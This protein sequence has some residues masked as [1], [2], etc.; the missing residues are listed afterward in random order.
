M[1]GMH[2]RNDA[3]GTASVR[4]GQ[5]PR[6]QVPGIQRATDEPP[7]FPTVRTA[8]RWA[9]QMEGATF[10]KSPQYGPPPPRRA[11]TLDGL[12]VQERVAQ[13]AWIRQATEKRLRRDELEVVMAH[14]AEGRGRNEARRIVSRRVAFAVRKRDLGRALAMRHFDAHRDS[15]PTLASIAAEF[16]VPARTVERL[17]AV[18]G[19]ELDRLLAEVDER[20]H[21]LFVETG[22]AARV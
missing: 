7:L 1:Q 18:I 17:S 20:L 15:C 9:W 21:A 16:G 2:T 4:P 14:Y 12:S 22:I 11:S 19:V 8:L 10:C 5:E 3:M 13:A 6:A